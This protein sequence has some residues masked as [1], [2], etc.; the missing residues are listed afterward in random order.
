MPT[1]TLATRQPSPTADPIETDANSADR[2]DAF[3][4]LPGLYR[5]ARWIIRRIVWRLR[6]LEF[7]LL[8]VERELSSTVKVAWWRK[9]KL[10]RRGFLS[11]SFVLYDLSRN[12]W[13]DYLSDLDR[14]VSVR[15][16][17]RDYGVVLDDKL[18]FE[19]L[20]DQG[21]IPRPALHGVLDGT[22]VDPFRPDDEPRDLTQLLYRQGALV[23]K[24]AR[25]GGG[26]GVHLVQVGDGDAIYLN[27]YPVDIGEFLE[28]VTRDGTVLVYDRV[29]QHN[30]LSQI[31]PHCLNT[32]R[33][34]TMTDRDGRPFVACA[35]LRLGTD[36]SRPTD[37]WIRGGLC[38]EVELDQGRLGLAVRFPARSD[39]LDWLTV[40]PDTGVEISG[41]DVPQWSAV[42]ELALQAAGLV[43]SAPY[44]G[45]DVALSEQGPLLIEGNSYSGVNLFQVHA[46]L[47]TT[48]EIRDFF[49][50]QG[51][52]QKSGK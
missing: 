51:V 7:A 19:R 11:E 45:W 38:A 18:V 35:V 16:I 28:R 5:V 20:M 48:P 25:G 9:P 23:L 27:G 4:E 37:N 24:P 14:S 42:K 32:I 12:D 46:P 6:G 13:A 30:A 10:W 2:W 31:Y 29:R 36:A 26:K 52:I 22:R 41:Q 40:H 15:R 17:N 8:P 1:D 49:I 33:V 3:R 43:P 21:G 50:R 34:L 44:V 39:R 47:L